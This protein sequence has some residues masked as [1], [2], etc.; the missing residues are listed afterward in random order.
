MKK[1]LF[2]SNILIKCQKFVT[3]FND[4]YKLE[5]AFWEEIL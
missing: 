2:A 1:L 3:Y 5:A 4:S